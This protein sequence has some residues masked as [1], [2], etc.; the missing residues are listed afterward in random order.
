VLVR[1]DAYAPGGQAAAVTARLLNRGGQPMSDLPV[2]TDNGT[3]NIDLALSALGAND[4]VL[5]I[6]AKTDSGTAQEF[7]GFRVGR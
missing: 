4:Y 6:T 5:E 1:V 2:Q 3:A 7:V